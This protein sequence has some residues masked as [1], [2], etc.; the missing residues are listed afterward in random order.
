MFKLW[1]E[2]GVDFVT[3][4]LG[5]IYGLSITKSDTR[6][7]VSFA[8]IVA[9]GHSIVMKSVSNQ[10]RSYCYILDCTSAIL[11]VLISG[12]AGNV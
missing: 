10:L 2:Y 6:T 11:T 12:E 8:R 3:V 1:Q 4:R 9:E 7:S 5:L